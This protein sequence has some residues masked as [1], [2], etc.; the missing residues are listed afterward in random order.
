M[1]STPNGYTYMHMYIS[2][3]HMKRSL[4]SPF[5]RKTQI[6]STGDTTSYPLGWLLPKNRNPIWRG[7]EV[8]L[9]RGEIETSVY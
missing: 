2:S 8:L 6:K 7:C 5:I 4:T 9:R 3:K 1:D